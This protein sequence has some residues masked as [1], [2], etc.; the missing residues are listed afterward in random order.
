MIVAMKVVAFVLLVVIAGIKV[1][2]RLYVH[3]RSKRIA[4]TLTD[5]TRFNS[6]VGSE[7]RVQP[8]KTQRNPSPRR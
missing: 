4:L 8:E 1:R 2:R 6:V 3:D 5:A 7:L